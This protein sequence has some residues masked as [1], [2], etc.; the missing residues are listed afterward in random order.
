MTYT[1]S[2]YLTGVAALDISTKG[3]RTAAELIAAPSRPVDY[4]QRTAELRTELAGAIA[5]G[6]TGD[7]ELEALAARI[8]ARRPGGPLAT[9]YS[10]AKG[11]REAQAGNA[12][13]ADAKALDAALARALAELRSGID[14]ATRLVTKAGVDIREMDAPR[15]A[16]KAG[17]LVAAALAERGALRQR[18]SDL[19]HFRTELEGP[20]FVPTRPRPAKGVL[21]RAEAAARKAFGDGARQAMPNVPAAG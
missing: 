7:A 15:L 20:G 9:G 17:P 14:N 1:L 4:D 3:T 11:M 5:E 8:E 10:T 2:Y 6:K 12:L 21:T 19:E 18:L 13:R 16:I